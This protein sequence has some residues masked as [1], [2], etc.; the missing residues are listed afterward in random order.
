MSKLKK[1]NYIV[2]HHAAT[3]AHMDVGVD[4]IRQWHI[5]RGFNDIGYHYLIRRNSVIEHGRDEKV[6][7]A[8]VKNYNDESIGICIVGGLGA[9]G[10][11][12]NN[13]TDA[14]MNALGYLVRDLSRSYPDAIVCGHRDLDKKKPEC[15]MFDVAKWWAKEK[16]RRHGG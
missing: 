15:P 11:G 13:Y 6:Q 10:Q 5:A 2:I 12:E 7:G 1:V 8:H 9:N 14:Q 3:P 4:E 16:D